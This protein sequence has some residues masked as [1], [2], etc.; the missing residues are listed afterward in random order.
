MFSE[1]SKKITSE[2]DTKTKK[3][4]GIFFTPPNTIENMVYKCWFKKRKGIRH[5]LEPSC[6]SC[7]VIKCIDKKY[8]GLRIT[9]VEFNKQIYDNI[10]DLKFD[11]KVHLY[12]EDFLK[13]NTNVKYDL[14]IGN[15]PYYIMKNA[16][17]KYHEYYD[18]RPNIYIL[19]II[20]CLS[21]L[22]DDGILS[23]V[24]PKNF[25][26]CIYYNKLRK[27]I[28]KKYDIIDISNCFDQYLETQQD[29]VIMIVRNRKPRI[30]MSRYFTTLSDIVIFGNI[31]SIRKI[32]SLCQGTT[33]DKLGFG[34]KVGNIVW[35]QV[36]NN[37]KDDKKYPRL[38]YSSDIKDNQ[39]ILADFRNKDKK[40]Y[41]NIDKEPYKG[42]SLVVNRG[43]GTGQYK[44][45]YCLIT[46]ID[47]YYVE[48][49]LI[50]IYAK[51]KI[52]ESEKLELYK[53]IIESFKMDKTQEFIDLYFSNNAIN[54]FELQ[55]I[56][57]IYF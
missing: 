40:H 54:T 8:D 27:Y 7:E 10:K 12:N 16:E 32:K 36:K 24:L 9:G 17:K 29:T 41:I 45:N 57:P 19:F 3:E 53:K 52:N 15:P 26:N 18:G 4:H 48:N 20:K 42:I 22:A 5:I 11:N 2:L 44:F 30:V 38:I 50:C 6:G 13:W 34:V 28:V 31:S 39:L 14:I 37:L 23:F 21:L 35:N 33:L 43:Y 55:N 25:L 47:K 56:L 1:L 46:G 51:K 49:H